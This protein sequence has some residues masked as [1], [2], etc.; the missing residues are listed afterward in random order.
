MCIRDRF[1]DADLDRM[2]TPEQRRAL[3]AAVLA[4]RA[5]VDMEQARPVERRW[6]P[7]NSYAPSH[8]A[9]PPMPK[10][11]QY[12]GLVRNASDHQLS[13]QEQ[14]YLNR[15]RQQTQNGWAQW[16][17]Q[18][19]LGNALPGGTKQ[20]LS[21]NQPRTGIAISGGGYRAMLHGLGVVQGFDSRNETA[22]QRGVGGFL[23]LTDYVAGLSGG[24]WA[25]GSMAMNNWPTTQE[26]LQ[27]F[28][29]L[30]SNLVIPSNDKI[31]FYHDLLKDVSA[32]KLSLIHI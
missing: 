18:V 6:N 27:H 23:Q 31:S 20:F 29:N 32:K 2:T 12:V 11:N 9:C 8:V 28:Y 7:T 17:N 13:P 15:H 1:T 14:D 5:K 22:K 30:D 4:A 24:S 21:K 10:G 19:G 26:Q 3:A 25:T 16:L